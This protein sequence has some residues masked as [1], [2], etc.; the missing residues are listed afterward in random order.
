MRVHHVNLRTIHPVPM[1][2]FY[3]S[4]GLDLIGCADLGGPCTL[5]LGED[6]GAT[7]ELTVRPEPDRD[8]VGNPGTGHIAFV[9]DDLDRELD[10]LGGVGIVAE[11]GPFHPGGRS[12][13][14][15]AFL[16]DPDGNHVE[17]VQAPFPSVRD[18]LPG[19][20]SWEG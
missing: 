16:R 13:V 15:V 20:L 12:D 18:P 6:G 11:T 8:W 4:L 5:Y 10:R 2:G 9:V 1:V 17:L 19:G 3:R 14:H 7:L